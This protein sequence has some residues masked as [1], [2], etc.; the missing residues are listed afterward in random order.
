M[1]IDLGGRAPELMAPFVLGPAHLAEGYLA[2]RPPA[3]APDRS[4]LGRDRLHA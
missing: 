1:K 4:V 2:A 3:D